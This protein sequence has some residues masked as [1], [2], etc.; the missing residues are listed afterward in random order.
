M[1]LRMYLR[2]A[3]R[4]GFKADVVD[5]HEGEEAGIKSVTVRLS[6]ASTPMACWQSEIGVHRLVRISP[7][8]A[9]AR[10]PHFVRHR[11]RLAGDRR[12]LKID[13]RSEEDLRVDTYRVERRGRPARQHD[14]L[15]RAHHAPPDRHRRAVPE[16]ALAAQESRQRHE[17]L[18]ARLYEH[19]MEKKRAEIAQARRL[20]ARHQLR[21]PDPQ[22]VL[23]AVPH[24]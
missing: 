6:T 19:E 17:E 23:H 8:D 16:R 10:A 12:R 11:F 2:W 15:R 21:Q 1:L 9:N 20:Q 5:R 13:I 14:R 3:E 24:D 22:Y 18:R 4:Q 7:F